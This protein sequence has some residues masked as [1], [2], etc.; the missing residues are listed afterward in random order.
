MDRR[1]F[2]QALSQTAA[3]AVAGFPAR[4]A[5]SQSSGVRSVAVVG[6]GIVGSCIA[7]NLAKRGADV[8]VLD[9]SLPA[10]QASGNTFAWINA[11]YPNKPDSYLNL[12]RASLSEYRSLAADVDLPIRWGGS[13]EWVDDPAAEALL[14]S[15]VTAY[16]ERPGAATSI[17]DAETARRIEPNVEFGSAT[18]FAHSTDDGAIDSPVAAQTIFDRT[19]ELGAEGRLFTEVKRLRRRRNQ[20][21]I[22]TA[23]G[24]IDVDRVIIAAGIGTAE[25]AASVDDRVDTITRSTPGIIATTE[26]VPE[27][28]NGVLYGPGFHLHQ[29]NDGR[30]VIGE[31]A[32]APGSDAHES[33]SRTRPNAFPDASTAN[34]H[35]LRLLGAAQA[36]LPK[37]S[38]AKQIDVGIG[39]RPMPQ[40][41]LPMVGYGDN[42]GVYYATMHSGVSLAPIIGKLV[43]AEILDDLRVDALEPFRP[44]RLTARLRRRPKVAA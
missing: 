34:R 43:A 10:Q 42:S 3:I 20:T 30:V 7:Y 28:L 38:A 33:L 29:Q 44:G 40:D 1:Y 36:M 15:D 22:I 12:R 21:R 5:F 27:M 41:G 6:A 39:W 31:K 8:V 23:L 25:I 26:P 19:L 24:N 13:L 11:S 17:V 35:A 9:K 18:T 37:L 32:G 16:A 14:K 2:L 4:R